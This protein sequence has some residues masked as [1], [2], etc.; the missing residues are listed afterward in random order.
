MSSNIDV[1]AV[2]HQTF[3]FAYLINLNVIY[4]IQ[5]DY[6][7]VHQQCRNH[8]LQKLGISIQRL[9]QSNTENVEITL[10][11]GLESLLLT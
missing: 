11:S 4:L 7:Y 10:A 5:S 9:T 2:K 1:V 6:V 3:E 8:R